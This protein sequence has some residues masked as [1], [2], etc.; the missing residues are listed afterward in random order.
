MPGKHSAVQILDVL[1]QLDCSH[2]FFAF[3]IP[4]SGTTFLQMMLDSHPKISCPSEHQFD[5]FLNSIPQCLTRYNRLLQEVDRRTARQGPEQFKNED[6][7][8]MFKVVVLF[9]LVAAA[10]GSQGIE[11]IGANDNAIVTRFPFYVRQ[12]PKARFICIVRDPRDQAI[13]AWRHNL[14]VEKNFMARAK[15]IENWCRNCS[16]TW[17]TQMK[18]LALARARKP[19]NESLLFLRYEDLIDDPETQTKRAFS[20]LGAETEPKL[21]RRIIEKNSFESVVRR[22]QEIG[23]ENPFFRRGNS[24]SWQKELDSACAAIFPRNAKE[25]MQHFGYLEKTS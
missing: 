7:D 1:K 14:R 21:I 8:L 11:W 10:R 20:H 13:S 2:V 22:N 12:F 5:F 17:Q 24:G 4:K 16:K 18:A 25:M 3:G 6:A 9:A 23:Q 19:L 15:S